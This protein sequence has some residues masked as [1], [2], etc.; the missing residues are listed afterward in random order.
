MALLFPRLLSESLPVETPRSGVWSTLAVLCYCPNLG[1]PGRITCQSKA[2]IPCLTVCME[3][4]KDHVTVRRLSVGYV[5]LNQTSWC[6]MA[7]PL[8]LNGTR[9]HTAPHK[10]RAIGAHPLCGCVGCRELTW[11]SKYSIGLCVTGLAA[12]GATAYHFRDSA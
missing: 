10:G 8:P 6:T 3:Y 11:R 2:S 9:G 12:S 5:G 7:P 1:P 4:G